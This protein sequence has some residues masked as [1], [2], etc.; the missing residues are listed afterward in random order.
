MVILCAIW[1]TIKKLLNSVITY[2]KENNSVFKD[3][4]ETFGILILIIISMF[5]P[6]IIVFLLIFLYFKETVN[7]DTKSKIY[8]ICFIIFNIVVY[9]FFMFVLPIPGI[10]LI[11]SFGFVNLI[12]LLID[13]GIGFIITFIMFLF[14]VLIFIKEKFKES[15]K[16]CKNKS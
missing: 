4:I 12:M 5:M 8:L 9:T 15:L 1:N 10:D 7:Y 13:F 2:V 14:Y 16:E 3:L 6:Y 11:T